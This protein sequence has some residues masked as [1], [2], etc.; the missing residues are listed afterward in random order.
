MFF[1]R[2]SNGKTLRHRYTYLSLQY[3]VHTS[4]IYRTIALLSS[5]G[6]LLLILFLGIA[7]VSIRGPLNQPRAS[8][9]P[10]AEDSGRIACENQ[11]IERPTKLVWWTMRDSCIHMLMSVFIFSPVNRSPVMKPKTLFQSNDSETKTRSINQLYASYMRC[12]LHICMDVC[13]YVWGKCKARL[14]CANICWL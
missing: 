10:F 6:R 12:L 4:T 3:I 2:L 11:L 7:L 9:F 8:C 5:E 13:M 14:Q 1:S